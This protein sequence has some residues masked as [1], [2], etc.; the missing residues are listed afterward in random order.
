MED[1]GERIRL[2]RTSAGKSQRS[3][4]RDAG[5]SNGTISLIESGQSDPTVGQLKKILSVLNVSMAQFFE[6]NSEP[7]DQYFY[8]NEQLVEIGAGKISYKHV[9]DPRKNRQL[10]ILSEIYEPGA[11]T[12]PSMLRHEGEEGG[13]IISGELEVQ[14]LDKKKKLRA[15]DAYQFPSHLPHRFRNTGKTKCQLISACTPPSF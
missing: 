12:G 11:D 14:V 5:V 4:A 10:Q 15:G 9:S 7:A 13:I 6:P 1:L 2:L 8:T 3:L